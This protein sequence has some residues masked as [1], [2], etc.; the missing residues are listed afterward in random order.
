M[1]VDEIKIIFSSLV[2]DI[3]A[4][5]CTSQKICHGS[6]RKNVNGED[7]NDNLIVNNQFFVLAFILRSQ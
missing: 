2:I 7:Y 5:K 1:Y 4:V 6:Y 3:I